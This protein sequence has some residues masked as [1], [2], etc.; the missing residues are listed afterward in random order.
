MARYNRKLTH[1]RLLEVLKYD[2]IT[3]LFTRHNKTKKKI[4]TIGNSGY[5]IISIDQEK[6]LAHRLAWFYVKKKFP[7]KLIDHKNGRKL[8]NWFANLREADQSQNACNSVKPNSNTTGYKG[9]SK[10]RLGNY[11]ATIGHNHKSKQIGTFDTALEAYHAYCKAAEK[12]HGE[13]LKLK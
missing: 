3:G 12:L 10:T 8:D 5:L 11:R 7:E 13:F 9:V 2:E 4:G 6:H 1:K